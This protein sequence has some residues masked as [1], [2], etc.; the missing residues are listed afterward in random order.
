ML[1]V[2]YLFAK[3]S[4]FMNMADI[5]HVFWNIKYNSDVIDVINHDVTELNADYII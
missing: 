1:G 4:Q 5:S 3:G 2:V